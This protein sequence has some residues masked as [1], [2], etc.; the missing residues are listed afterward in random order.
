MSKS[1]VDKKV[2]LNMIARRGIETHAQEPFNEALP[3][4]QTS[5]YPRGGFGGPT[6][7][8][9][10]LR[11]KMQF[12]NEYDGGGAS[13]FGTIVATDKDFEQILKKREAE[14]KANFDAWVGKNFHTNSVVDRAFLQ[15]VYPQYYKARVA[16]LEDKAKLAVQI[17]K[18]DLFGP[19]DEDD[20]E[21]IYL[22]QSGQVELPKN[23]NV[24]GYHSDPHDAAAEERK[25]RK[26]LWAPNR[27]V[28]TAERDLN[29]K[30]NENP[31]KTTNESAA[32]SQKRQNFASGLAADVPATNPYPDWQK[33]NILY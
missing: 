32:G 21:T 5:S 20:L 3:G 26:Q 24:I 15:Q 13:P 2:R 27:Y 19:Q 23:W 31:F 10:Y 22:L 25:F 8:D 6:K 1:L 4:Q 12:V 30:N 33:K 11:M 16:E 28:G 17:A 29:A 14:E 7:R 18:I 9:E